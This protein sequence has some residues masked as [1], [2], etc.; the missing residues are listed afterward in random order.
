VLQA[1]G[2]VEKRH[3][4]GN[5]VRRPPERIR[6]TSGKHDEPQQT[7][8]DLRIHAS[9]SEVLADSLLSSLMDVP[10]G[11]PVTER[12][13]LSRR[14]GVP[15]ILTRTYTVLPV[16]AVRRL[17]GTSPWG[18]D[19]SPAL[20]SAGVYIAATIEHVTARPPTFA[21]AEQLRI[22]PGSPV[23]NVERTSTDASGKII[24]AAILVLPGDR[25]EAV[26]VTGPTEGR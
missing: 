15:Y 10:V 14:D 22:A 4:L 7:G 6:Y 18:D 1:E 16:E 17:P 11:T 8:D 24:E 13:L 21:E 23:L 26:F 25:T 9:V 3:G 20:A 2:L 12:V 5:F 19:T